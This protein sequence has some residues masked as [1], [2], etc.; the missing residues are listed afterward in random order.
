M[1]SET[2]RH[3]TKSNGSMLTSSDVTAALSHLVAV[4]NGLVVAN[5]HLAGW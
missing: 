4:G 3:L 5:D 1:I 2:R